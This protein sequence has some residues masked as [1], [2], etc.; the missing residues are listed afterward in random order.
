MIVMV[1]GFTLKNWIRL[2]GMYC[3]KS[4][5][6]PPSVNELYRNSCS[7]LL[8]HKIDYNFSLYG[9]PYSQEVIVIMDWLSSFIIK[10]KD[11]TF[12]LEIPKYATTKNK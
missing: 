5:K 4:I 10:D 8:A 9:C 7:I 6:I 2:T 1:S 11:N 12:S 3:M